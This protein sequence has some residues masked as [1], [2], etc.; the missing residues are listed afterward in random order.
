MNEGVLFRLKFNLS[1]EGILDQVGSFFLRA[2]AVF[3]RGV[4]VTGECNSFLLGLVLLFLKSGKF[5]R[6]EE[7]LVEGTLNL[8]GSGISLSAFVNLT[9][10]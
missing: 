10:G 4:G 3:L 2:G 8:I 7:F 6:S 5:G 9:R 1:L